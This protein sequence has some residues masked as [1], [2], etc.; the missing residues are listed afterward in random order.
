MSQPAVRGGSSVSQALTLSGLF[1]SATD[2]LAR[3][4]AA[5]IEALAESLGESAS[6]IPVP[7]TKAEWERAHR[8]RWVLGRLLSE[9][10]GR[11]EMLRRVGDPG[12]GWVPVGRR[13]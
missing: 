1:E 12:A 8:A 3:L 13:R 5:G 4:D 11:M 7:R 6:R 9:T 10:R 2:A